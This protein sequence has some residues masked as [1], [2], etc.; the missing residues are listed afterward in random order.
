M[1]EMDTRSWEQLHAYHDGELRGLGRWRFERRLRRSPQLRRELD[2]LAR[3]GDRVR[4]AEPRAPEPDLWDRIEQRLPAVD[5]Q[6]A[7]QR[8]RARAGALD[9]LRPA[10]AVAVAAA[11]LVAVYLGIFQGS[12]PQGGVVRWIDSGERN[13][14]VLESDAE[15]DVTII[16]V[17]D[18]KVEGAARGGSG[19]VA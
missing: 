3:L 12:G 19:D 13:V 4:S 5:A 6:R 15:S 18:P 9:W 10:G 2:A 8:D 7:E 1:S 17:L 16:W 14:M 11:A